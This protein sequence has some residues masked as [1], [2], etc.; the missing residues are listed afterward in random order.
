MDRH[1]PGNADLEHGYERL[2]ADS[3]ESNAEQ[4]ARRTQ[5]ATRID[6]A[7]PTGETEKTPQA[8]PPTTSPETL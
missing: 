5:Y 8:Q 6:G 1:T 7:H 2:A 3:A 4:L